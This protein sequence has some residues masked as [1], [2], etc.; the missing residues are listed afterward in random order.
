MTLQQVALDAAAAVG[1]HHDEIGVDL[2]GVPENR[3]VRR[4][5]F[6]GRDDLDA[7]G[8]GRLDGLGDDALAFRL[9]GA[10]EAAGVELGRVEGALVDDVEGVQRRVRRRREVERAVERLVGGGAPVHRDENPV[11]H[12][13]RPYD[14]RKQQGA[15][16]YRGARIAAAMG[17][18]GTV[19]VAGATREAAYS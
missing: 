1:A 17:G 18:G 11:V 12:V 6:D 3:P 19:G 7:V 16:R 13:A 15:R 8:L 4:A 10:D 5:V 2:L 14:G 9:V